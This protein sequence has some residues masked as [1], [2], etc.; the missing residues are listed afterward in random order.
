MNYLFNGHLKKKKKKI[1]AYIN[2][3]F[4]KAINMLFNK[5]DPVFK[6]I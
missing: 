2:I 5:G 3:N 4:L 6:D 1:S